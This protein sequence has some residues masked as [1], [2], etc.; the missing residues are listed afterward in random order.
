MGG[1]QFFE[2]SSMKSM[3]KLINFVLGCA[4]LKENLFIPLVDVRS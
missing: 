1:V 4:W 2:I 3:K